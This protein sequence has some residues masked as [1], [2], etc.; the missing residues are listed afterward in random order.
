[1]CIRGELFSTP[2]IYRDNKSEIYEMTS[3]VV[4][5][6]RVGPSMQPEANV[7]CHCQCIE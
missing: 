1:M 4:T 6:K 5:S 7:T 3:R 2:P